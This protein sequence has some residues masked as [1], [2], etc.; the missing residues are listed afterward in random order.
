MKVA[1]QVE[2]LSFDHADAYVVRC[3]RAGVE[4]GD[5]WTYPVVRYSVCSVKIRGDQFDEEAVE[6]IEGET[7]QGKHQSEQVRIGETASHVRVGLGLEHGAL[8]DVLSL[9]SPNP[10]RQRGDKKGGWR[11]RRG[12]GRT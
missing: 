10:P 3:Q 2:V 6:E 8:V 9:S 5:R 1:G 11:R 4:E 12:K 7:E